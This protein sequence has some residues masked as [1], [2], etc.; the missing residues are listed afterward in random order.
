M[1]RTRDKPRQKKTKRNNESLNKE[2]NKNENKRKKKH[3]EENPFSSDSLC[4]FEHGQFVYRF[5]IS[6]VYIKKIKMAHLMHFMMDGVFRLAFVFISPI[7]DEELLTKNF[8]EKSQC[9]IIRGIDGDHNN[10]FLI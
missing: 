8:I 5:I 2:E 10:I 3:E 9:K 7:F 6:L 1:K 4:G